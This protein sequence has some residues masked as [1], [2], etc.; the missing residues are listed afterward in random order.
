MSLVD[1]SDLFEVPRG[2]SDAAP[3]LVIRVPLIP[4]DDGVRR[5]MMA[6][7][8]PRFRAVSPK[9][10]PSFVMTYTSEKTRQQEDAIRAVA[11]DAMRGRPLLTG[12]LSVLMFAYFPVP[13]SWPLHRREAAYAG[14]LRPS[15]TPDADNIFKLVDAL[16]PYRDPKSKI[17]VPIVWTD[18]STIVDGRIIKVFA[19]RLPG[20]VIEIWPAPAPPA[21]WQSAPV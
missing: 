17:L 15:S 7:D 9:G 13:E 21:P 14:R 19:K 10:R 8:R 11:V 16:N 18:D 5:R 1:R 3:L 12:Y 4:D 6:K 2:S 20:L